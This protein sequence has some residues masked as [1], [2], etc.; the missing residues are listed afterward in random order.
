MCASM[1]LAAASTK[2]R[3]MKICMQPLDGAGTDNSFDSTRAEKAGPTMAQ[4]TFGGSDDFSYEGA[5]PPT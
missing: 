4:P 3:D 1:Q 2:L 5:R